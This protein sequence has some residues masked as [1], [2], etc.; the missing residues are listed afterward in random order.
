MIQLNSDLTRGLDLLSSKQRESQQKNE[1]VSFN[2]VESTSVSLTQSNKQSFT[3]FYRSVQQSVGQSIDS[4]QNQIQKQ[5][6]EKALEQQEKRADVAANNILKFIELRLQ[7]DKKDGATLEQLS[8]RIDAGLEGFEL[9]YK[10]ANEA[11]GQLNLLNPELESEISLTQSKVLEGIEQLKQTYLGAVPE[12]TDVSEDTNVTDD[13]NNDMPKSASVT[14]TQQFVQGQQSTQAN[15]FSFDLVTADGD[16]VTIY[17]SALM[18]RKNESGYSS[19]LQNGQLVEMAYQSYSEIKQSEFMFS[20]E[21]DLD[22]DELVA[23]NNLLNNVNDLAKDFYSGDVETAFNKAL[24]MDYDAAEISEFSISLTQIKNFT[25]YKAYQ[26]DT[27]LF[28]ANAIDDLK[29]LAEFSNDISNTLA[30]LQN[31][32]EHPRDLL[33]DV[34]KHINALHK[35]QDYPNSQMDFFEFANQLMDKID[36]LSNIEK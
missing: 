35:P 28:N 10:Q 32:F 29:P 3:F 7:Q 23:I 14:S 5:M 22:E 20:V 8:S 19:S 12:D 11:L 1:S 21:G 2:K 25:A 24:S 31:L 6:A 34:T 13:P 16:K 9:G 18:A 15:E 4:E 26:T 17:T 30:T 33:F 36:Q 27:P